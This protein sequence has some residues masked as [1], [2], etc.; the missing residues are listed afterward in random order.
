MDEVKDIDVWSIL[1]RRRVYLCAKMRC[2]YALLA[3]LYEYRIL[4]RQDFD[5]LFKD[6]MSHEK[7]VEYLIKV[8]LKKD[9][10]YFSKFCKILRH[11]GVNQLHVA[12]ELEKIFDS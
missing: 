6:S 1:E 4:D 11:A 3:L 8:L 5:R 2:N 9:P 7:K 12:D 10:K